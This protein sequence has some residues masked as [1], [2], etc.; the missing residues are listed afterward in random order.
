MLNKKLELISNFSTEKKR[1]I[2]YAIALSTIPLFSQFVLM[3]SPSFTAYVIS[4]ISSFALLLIYLFI[5]KDIKQLY[6]N[7]KDKLQRILFLL[8]TTALYFK[9]IL[10]VFA[11][12][13]AFNV[14]ISKSKSTLIIG[15]VHL[16]MLGLFSLF[17][18]WYYRTP[19]RSTLF[20]KTGISFLILGILLTEFLLFTQ[21]VLNSYFHTSIDN[22]YFLLF[23]ASSII[24]VGILSLLFHYF[25]LTKQ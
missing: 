11:S 20:E 1:L 13:P 21:G 5:F 18:I 22:Y 7:S 12:L 8:F 25:R 17:F 24:P 6:Y 10:Q 14:I 4:F 15:Y 16:V 19:T 23:V 3:V 9:L 2:Y